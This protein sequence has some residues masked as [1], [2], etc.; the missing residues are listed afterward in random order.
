MINLSTVYTFLSFIFRLRNSFSNGVLVR[1][2]SLHNG[3][4]CNLVLPTGDVR[5]ETEFSFCVCAWMYECGSLLTK[6]LDWVLRH[7]FVNRIFGMNSR[8]SSLMGE[9]GITVYKRGSLQ[10]FSKTICVYGYF[11][12]SH[13]KQNQMTSCTTLLFLDF[14]YT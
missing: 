13:T 10:L 8:S 14:L 2:S 6:R 11:L 9:F 7:V 4:R 12:T 3:L 1:E 5:T